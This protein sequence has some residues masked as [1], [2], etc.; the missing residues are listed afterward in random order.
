MSKNNWK[1]HEQVKDNI[2][3]ILKSGKIMTTNVILFELKQRDFKISYGSVARR[4]A[5]LHKEKKV[6][7]IESVRSNQKIWSTSFF[8]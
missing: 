3:K 7:F 1:K 6:K 2:L 8:K 4:L 5:E